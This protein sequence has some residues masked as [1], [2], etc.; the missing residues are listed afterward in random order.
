MMIAVDCRKDIPFS[1]EGRHNDEADYDDKFLMMNFH[2][3][4]NCLSSP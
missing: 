2:P 4:P 3:S 1:N